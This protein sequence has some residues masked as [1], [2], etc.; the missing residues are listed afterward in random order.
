MDQSDKI[1]VG[2]ITKPH[3]I[4]GHVCIRSYCENP[5]QIFDYSPITTARG[6][7][8]QLKSI[9]ETRGFIVAEI[10]DIK[11]RTAAELLAQTELYIQR[12]QLVDLSEKDTN[13][14][15]VS[16][17][18]GLEIISSNGESLGTVLSV[19]NYG[20]GDLL[21]CRGKKEFMVPFSEEAISSIDQDQKKIVVTEYTEAFIN[22]GRPL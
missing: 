17:L 7:V 10:N 5:M 19:E 21:D 11:T 16:D 22:D 18:I 2:V 15:Y 9:G 8:M 6:D 1:C 14:F 20:A 13:V 12:T 3:G 4:K